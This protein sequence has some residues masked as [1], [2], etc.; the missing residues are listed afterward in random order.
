MIKLLSIEQI[1]DIIKEYEN[2]LIANHSICTIKESLTAGICYYIHKEYPEEYTNTR[3]ILEYIRQWIGSKLFLC[4]TVECALKTGTY[5]LKEVVEPRIALLK[6]ILQDT[7]NNK[8]TKF[9]EH[10]G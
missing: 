9:V 5:S 7:K 2:L 4:S 8:L 10:E 6:H 1:E 3:D